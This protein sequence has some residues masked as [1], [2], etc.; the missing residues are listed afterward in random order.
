MAQHW[1]VEEAER[2]RLAEQSGKERLQKLHSRQQQQQQQ[3]RDVNTPHQSSAQH[4]APNY[5]NVAPSSEAQPYIEALKQAGVYA[6]PNA[7]SYPAVQSYNPY[8]V[9]ADQPK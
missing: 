7:S 2:R 5:V 1:V 8:P 3:A 4:A 6:S 9:G